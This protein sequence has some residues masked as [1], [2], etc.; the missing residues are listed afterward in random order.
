[1]EV[2]TLRFARDLKEFG[3][4]LCHLTGTEDAAGPSGPHAD[5]LAA[6]FKH[7]IDE[8]T[9]LDEDL[10]RDPETPNARRILDAVACHLLT[11]AIDVY[12]NRLEA[13]QA[14]ADNPRAEGG[15]P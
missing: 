7:V 1:V 8:L 12:E 5:A 13:I 2:G 3:D 9:G 4:L 15:A 10:S 6:S 11:S 14:A